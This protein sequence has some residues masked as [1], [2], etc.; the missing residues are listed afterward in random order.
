MVEIC[1]SMKPQKTAIRLIH[2]FNPDIEINSFL[3]IT[4]LFWLFYVLFSFYTALSCT[5]LHYTKKPLQDGM[6]T[7][8]VYICVGGAS[9]ESCTVHTVCRPFK[10]IITWSVSLG[11]SN[12]VV[13]GRR[14]P[15]R[16]LSACYI[17][18]HNSLEFNILD[19]WNDIKLFFRNVFSSNWACK[20]R[21]H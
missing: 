17:S 3:C 7:F 18:C 11:A 15:V 14:E 5:G 12:I 16:D 8:Y 1:L 21:Q 4:Y 20:F 9:E 10:W 13:F 2:E 19:T 6:M